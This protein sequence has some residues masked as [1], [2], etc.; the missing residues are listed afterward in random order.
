MPVKAVVDSNIW[1][2]ALVAPMGTAAKLIDL[3]EKGKF[4]LVISEQQTAELFEV[5]S[6]TQ[7]T[8]KYRLD[9]KKVEDLIISVAEN[10]EHIFIG[11]SLIN[12]CRDPDDD[13]I[14]ET[15]IRGGAKYL[16]T[17]DK[18]ISSD[19]AV[20]ALLSQHGVTVISLSN[21]LALIR[22]D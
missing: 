7:F 16:V 1:V 19:N 20:S 21:F 4:K 22:K 12:W 10:A 8:T 18:D 17:G 13:V 15:A 5:L 3:W 6:R 2:S 11:K 14:I 9:E